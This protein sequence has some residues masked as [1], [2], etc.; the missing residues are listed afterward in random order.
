MTATPSPDRR[1]TFADITRAYSP[2]YVAALGDVLGIEG[3]YAD[4]P[5]DR[6]G[7]TK[8]GISLRFLVRCGQID[9]NRDGLA[10]FDLDMDGD[11]DRRDI[12]RLTKQDAAWL[13]HHYFWKQLGAEDL[14]K[15]IGE[16]VFDQGVNGGLVAARK[17]LQRAINACGAHVSDF[18]RL[19][20]D[21]L[22]GPQTRLQLYAVIEHP[23]LGLAAL[24]E[25]YREQVRARYRAIVAEDPSQRRFLTGWLARAD[26][27]GGAA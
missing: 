10:D 22:I 11:I 25:A 3:G 27:L 16:M 18:Q 6:G 1:D 19:A 20:V 17:L 4:D 14:P 7:A 21:G 12:Q 13:Y 23:G 2:R 9:R 15:P 26:H 5:A 24:A 8:Y